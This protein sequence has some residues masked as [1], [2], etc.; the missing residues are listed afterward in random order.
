MKLFFE[1]LWGGTTNRWRWGR[2]G[3]APETAMNNSVVP[4][5][6]KKMSGLLRDL[7]LDLS[8]WHRVAM[9]ALR[10]FTFEALE[11]QHTCCQMPDEVCKLSENDIADIEDENRKEIELLEVTIQDLQRAYR[12][13]EHQDN[14]A[15]KFTSFLIAEWAP[16]MQ[17]ILADLEANQ[18]TEDERLQA[19][20]IGVRWQ[21]AKEDDE[22]EEEDMGNIEYW[23]RELDKIMPDEKDT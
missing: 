17:R 3:T 11:I 20:E 7:K 19:E 9:L 8:E 5:I 4:E 21:P 23:L 12:D 6:A 22:L 18:M 13:F 10:Y 16:K 1:D 15:D 2:W 14:Q